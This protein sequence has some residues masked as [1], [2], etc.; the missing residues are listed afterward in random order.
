M[1][2]KFKTGDRVRWNSEAGMVSGTKITVHIS[3]FDYKGYRHHASA[4]DPQ[5]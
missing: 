3:D 2:T 5:Y 1:T 4:Q